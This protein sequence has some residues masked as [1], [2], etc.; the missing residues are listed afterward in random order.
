MSEGALCRSCFARAMG[1]E[2][3]GLAKQLRCCG[4]SEAVLFLPSP[5]SRELPDLVLEPDVHRSCFALWRCVIALYDWE[6]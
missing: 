5:G 2:N 4:G 6:L 1:C 3:G